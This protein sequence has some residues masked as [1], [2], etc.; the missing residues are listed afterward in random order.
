MGNMFL[1]RWA[2]K[3][4]ATPARTLMCTECNKI[5]EE[6]SEGYTF[7][8]DTEICHYCYAKHCAPTEPTFTPTIP[9]PIEDTPSPASMLEPDEYQ[10]Y[11]RFKN[12]Q[13]KAV[14]DLLHSPEWE[15]LVLKHET[16]IADAIEE[17]PEKTFKQICDEYSLSHESKELPVFMLWV[18]TNYPKDIVDLTDY[19]VNIYT[20]EEPVPV[21]DSELIEPYSPVVDHAMDILEEEEACDECGEVHTQENT[22][23]EED[24]LQNPEDF[25]M[26]V[27]EVNSL[28]TDEDKETNPY[29]SMMEKLREFCGTDATTE[30][31]LTYGIPKK[32]DDWYFVAH[33]F[34]WPYDAWIT[35]YNPDDRCFFGYMSYGWFNDQDAEYG[36]VSIDEYLEISKARPMSAIQ[37]DF[38]W[39]ACTYDELEAKHN[40]KDKPV[41][42]A[43]H[44]HI[45]IDTWETISESKTIMA[46]TNH[47]QSFSSP[48]QELDNTPAPTVKVR[49]YRKYQ[50]SERETDLSQRRRDNQVQDESLEWIY[51]HYSGRGKLHEI[52]FDGNFH[53]YTKAKQEFELWQ[54]FTP[55][56]LLEKMVH[57]VNPYTESRVIDINCGMW[58]VFNYIE[59]ES[60]C[61]WIELDS[62]CV[63]RARKLFPGACVMYSDFRWP[64]TRFRNSM[65][66]SIGN[67]PFNLVFGWY[68]DHALASST[69][70]EDWGKGNILSQDLYVDQT[71]WYLREWG[72]S[73]FVVP[74]TWL[75]NSLKHKKINDYINN[76][77]YFL[78]EFTLPIDTFKEYQINFPCKVILLQKHIAWVNWDFTKYQWDFE[79]FYNS[80]AGKFFMTH[81]KW[82]DDSYIRTKYESL[83]SE[84][85]SNDFIFHKRDKAMKALY[86]YSIRNKTTQT[87][88]DDWEDPMQIIR[89]ESQKAKQGSTYAIDQLEKLTKK[90]QAKIRE[91]RNT[92]LAIRIKKTN[93]HIVF[94]RMSPV[95][96]EFL[97]QNPRA[98]NVD[99]DIRT[100][101]LPLRY[102]I[103]E[104]VIKE[105]TRKD[106]YEWLDWL[107]KTKFTM[108]YKW[109]EQTIEVLKELD[110]KA[111]IDK[112][113]N[114]FKINSYDT[115]KL[116][117]FPEYEY[118]FETLSD[119]TFGDKKLL[120][121]QQE[122][123][124][125]ML[126]KDYALV[127][128]DTWLGKTLTWIAWSSI[129]WGR[130]LVVSPAVNILDPWA[131][132]LKE[133][134]PEKSV[135]VCKKW[136]D[137]YKYK[138]ED[139]LVVSLEGLPWISRAMRQLH[140][141]NLI[142]DESDNTKSKASIRFKELR[143]LARKIKRKLLMS[144]TPT[145][146]NIN[147]IYNQI[148]LLCNNSINML[149]YAKDK[150]EYDRSW[151]EWRQIHNNNYMLPFPA[152]WWHKHFT[153]TFSPKKIT[154]FGAAE[155]N[156]D[157]FQKDDF[158]K[159]IRSIRFTRD[160]NT[161]KPRINKL[162][163]IED[164]GDY[165]EYQQV[166][167]PMNKKEWEV[168]EYILE[169]FAS[170][171]EE[172]YRKK[173]DWLTA[174]M[175]VIMRQIMSFMQGTS[176]PWTFKRK[177]R[178][179]EWRCLMDESWE[180]IY[181]NIYKEDDPHTSSKI[182]KALDIIEKAFEEW[183][184][185]MMASPWRETAD[186]LE[187]I[188]IHKW[189]KTFRIESEMSKQKRAWIVS[190][191]R[192]YDWPAI[193]TGTMGCLKSWLN[194]P[195]VSVV[196]AESYPWN[197]AQL[198]QY[199]ARAVRLNSTEKTMIY[200]LCAEW[201][202]D[203][204]VFALML[205]KE[206]VNKF[207][208]TSDD[209]LVDEL[210]KNFW[211][212]TDIF[213]SAL[214]MV[215]ERV[216]WRMRGTIQWSEKANIT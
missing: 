164:T 37:R 84:A 187:E 26:D 83:R 146:N 59:N 171:V 185:V 102:K 134:V 4:S 142:V 73:I 200:C 97:N 132:Q 120:P 198:H 86:E 11:L 28:L 77:F 70:E 114:E 124:A 85:K 98:Y 116:S 189:Y 152:W 71:N 54:F 35:E 36:Y 201:S 90:Y 65:D 32:W 163:E 94:D 162:L 29:E 109:E 57:L 8:K 107:D 82:L 63:S 196:I 34:G 68:Y 38:Y 119:M 138:W 122:D 48:V 66:Y 64:A 202:F 96:S 74:E 104:L 50:P 126:M 168:Y 174:S 91:K 177:L 160:F 210:A 42:I 81:K 193:I 176:H 10:D 199:A 111:F 101:T 87:S 144:G 9:E 103:N 181:E 61:Y 216:D 43:E 100:K 182:E 121:H 215:K 145:R 27:S 206:V 179:E 95:I 24:M 105:D 75:N 172:F 194:L 169:E 156:Q 62:D 184:K 80:S 16:I 212:T 93:Y 21:E 150:I 155:T 191:F 3:S 186:K 45:D 30:S 40:P 157:I 72:I 148:E 170:E 137:I 211:T 92:K 115:E 175:L 79:N 53:D 190:E 12:E 14:Q 204:N 133:Y 139:Y 151:K 135:F 39:T 192:N 46:D 67:P 78:A 6:P 141:N 69:N 203:I 49:Q 52:S 20:K 214:Q 128:H 130:T 113:V 88:I 173:H 44:K 106:F 47:P 127:S 31:A 99:G 167:V 207:V 197:F 55:D 125:W 118:W 136:K 154:C 195:E 108:T 2:S 60:N 56:W 89:L 1:D 143:V 166:L 205:K 110:A 5:F 13:A 183:R 19:Y 159:L 188:F 153:E 140:F 112:K 158:D 33:L 17:P 149:C 23:T 41:V 25:G 117:D 123:L 208:R 76:H 51:N 161:E 213:S 209:V 58:R 147:E 18:Q 129:K 22:D 7:I 165:K 180:Y 15:W 178:D 131:Q